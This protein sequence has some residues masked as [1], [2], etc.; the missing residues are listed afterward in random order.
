MEDPEATLAIP[1]TQLENLLAAEKRQA[2][3]AAVAALPEQMRDCL[4]LRLHHQLAYKEI[5][6][7][8]KLSI[9]TVKAHLFRARKK[10]EDELAGFSL[11]DGEI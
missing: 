5:A 3:A 4:T 7:I 6:V 10:L 1:E 8:K 9:E 11:G 2:L